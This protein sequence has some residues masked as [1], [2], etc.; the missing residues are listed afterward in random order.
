MIATLA[1][2]TALGG[3]AT[4]FKADVARFQAQALPA[5]QGQTFAIAADD[6]ALVNRLEFDSYAA[7][8]SGQLVA[9]GYRQ[10]A[11]S[12]TADLVVRMSYNVDKGT[13]KLRSS[14]GFY[15]PFWDS[16]VGYGRGFH[17]RRAFR[18]SAFGYRYG[19]QVRH[20]VMQC[21]ACIAS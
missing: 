3:C 2:A 5:T 6:P 14:P 11:D 8:A 20:A 9:M 10:A 4:P 7:K 18:G 13:Q 17:G 16:W 1:L 15:D 21:K 12:N 19:Y